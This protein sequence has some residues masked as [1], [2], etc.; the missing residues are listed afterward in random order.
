V[1]PIARRILFSGPANLITAPQ[2]FQRAGVPHRCAAIL[3]AGRQIPSR[4]RNLFSGPAYPITALQS[5]QRAG[6]SHRRAAIISAGWQIPSPRH[7]LFH[8][9]ANSIAA[10]PSFQWAGKSHRRTAIFS[11]VRR[12]PSSEAAP[13]PL[14]PCYFDKWDIFADTWDCQYAMGLPV[15]IFNNFLSIFPISCHLLMSD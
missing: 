9:P 1:N 7:I 4:R 11:V 12:I 10:P 14:Q 8:E 2:S 13:C 5:F 6:E 15:C 3:S